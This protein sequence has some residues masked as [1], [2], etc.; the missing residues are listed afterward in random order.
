MSV[1]KYTNGAQT[2]L[3]KYQ[4]YCYGIWDENTFLENENECW[5]EFASIVLY[6]IC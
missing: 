3:W 1:N 6:V 4:I 2:I 5:H